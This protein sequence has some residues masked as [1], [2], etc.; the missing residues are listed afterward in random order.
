MSQFTAAVLQMVSGPELPENLAQTEDLISAAVRQGSEL[1]V[2]PENFYLMGT[3]EQ[4]RLRLREG[5][6]TGPLQQ[7]LAAQAKRHG[8]H[9]VAGSLPLATDSL[10]RIYSSCLVYDPSGHCIGRYDKRHLFDA[11]VHAKTGEQYRESACFA[12]GRK[13]VVLRTALAS[14]GLSICYDLRF[15]EQYRAMLEHTVQ[16][17][18]VPAAFTARTGAAHWEPL[19]RARAIENQCYVLAANQGGT[20]ARNRNTWGHSMILDPWGRILSQWTEGPGIACATID[21]E[22]QTRLRGDFPCLSHR[23]SDY[24]ANRYTIGGDYPS[25]ETAAVCPNRADKAGD[26][27]KTET[28]P[29]P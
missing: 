17:I 10:D 20:H 1:L 23:C 11:V 13:T 3:Q 6:G 28:N 29:E 2:L 22:Q 26:G 18:T 21:L 9:L 7:F 15:P 25:S 5:F 8:V 16:V 12:R 19:L 27:A 14:I 24:T 4:E